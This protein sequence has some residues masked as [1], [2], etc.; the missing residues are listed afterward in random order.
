M[1]WLPY[2]IRGVIMVGTRDGG[3]FPF[4]KRGSEPKN[5]QKILEKSQDI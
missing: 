1:G 3:Y 2:D 4:I 5:P